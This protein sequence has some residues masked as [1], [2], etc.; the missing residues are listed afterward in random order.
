MEIL[1]R[2]IQVFI[3]FRFEKMKSAANNLSKNVFKLPVHILR[4][5]SI[6]KNQ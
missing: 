2:L 4:M 6:L 3:L 5:N 1:F